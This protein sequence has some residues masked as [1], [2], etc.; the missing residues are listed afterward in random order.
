MTHHIGIYHT[1]HRIRVLKVMQD[2]C[3]Q[4]Y[5]YFRRASL[6]KSVCQLPK[7]VFV[8]ALF[9]LSFDEVLV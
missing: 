7:D 9:T 8:D 1:S 2:L 3:H 6:M 4:Q 5:V